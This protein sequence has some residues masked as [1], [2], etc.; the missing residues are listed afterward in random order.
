[1]SQECA[2]A[3]SVD[4]VSMVPGVETHVTVTTGHVTQCQVS[5]SVRLGSL[6]QDVIFPVLQDS[7]VLSV[8]RPVLPATQVSSI[9]LIIIV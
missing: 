1:M 9:I 7:M 4:L 8:A 2:A 3:H 5:V 6:V